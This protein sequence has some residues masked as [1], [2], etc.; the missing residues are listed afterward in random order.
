[1]SLTEEEEEDEDGGFGTKSQLKAI[2]KVNQYV[3]ETGTI[4][5]L[6]RVTNTKQLPTKLLSFGLHD[7][8]IPTTLQAAPG[9]PMMLT[10]TELSGSQFV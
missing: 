3:Y 4:F 8:V 6:D 1:M 5:V 9:Y 2:V 7:R 10:V